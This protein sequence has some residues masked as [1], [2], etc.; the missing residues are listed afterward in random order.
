MR[1]DPRGSI[2]LAA[3]FAIS[4]A[5]SAQEYGGRGFRFR[6]PSATLAVHG[7][8]ASPAAGSELFRFTTDE[9][10]L[11]RSD[12]LAGS[13][14]LDLAIMLGER[15][16]LVLGFTR[17]QSSTRSEFRD[18][19]DNLGAP[20]EQTTT[21]LRQPLTATLR[22]SFSTR[23]RS[24]GSYAWIPTR[25]VPFVGIGGGL[26]RY[27]FEQV[28]DF[29]DMGTQDVFTDRFIEEGWSPVGQLSGG[30]TLNLSPYLQFL[31]EVR[32]LRARGDRDGTSDFQGFDRLD[33][34]GVST[35]FG[36]SLRF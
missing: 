35:V 24:V 20:I 30:A 21:F 8:L 11:E 9:L 2:A 32:Y 5:A 14:G 17:D 28:G 23:G 19:V 36:I 25:V 22:Y 12:F 31:G 13:F 33:L 6:P 10:T 16:D 26:M 29:I 15:A 3:A 4:T 34:S 18:W 7:G 1:L 27:R